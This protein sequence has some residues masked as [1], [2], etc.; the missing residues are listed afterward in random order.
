MPTLYADKLNVPE[1]MNIVVGMY[2][3]LCFLFYF[4]IFCFVFCFVFVFVKYVL[5]NDYE[6]AH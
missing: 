4:F 2:L 6:S 5:L 1:D 3:A